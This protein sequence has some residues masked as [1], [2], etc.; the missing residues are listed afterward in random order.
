MNHSNYRTRTGPGHRGEV[1]IQ[2]IVGLIIIAL[3]AGGVYWVKSVLQDTMAEKALRDRLRQESE[4]S[5]E[6]SSPSK[7]NK[8]AHFWNSGDFQSYYIMEKKEEIQRVIVNFIDEQL[9][10]RTLS[11]KRINEIADQMIEDEYWEIVEE[12]EIAQKS[13]TMTVKSYDPYN[14]IPAD[15]EEMRAQLERQLQ[16][17]ENREEV[18][19][20]SCTRCFLVTCKFRDEKVKNTIQY[21]TVK[22][23]PFLKEQMAKGLVEYEGEWIPKEEKLQRERTAKGLVEYQGEWITPEEKFRREQA[24]KGLVEHQGEWIAKEEKIRREQIAKGLVEYDGKWIT[25]E[26]KIRRER[27]AQGLIEY[28]GEWITKEEKF[29]REQTAKGLVEYDGKWITPAEKLKREEAARNM[30]SPWEFRVTFWEARKSWK[31]PDDKRDLEAQGQNRIALVNLECEVIRQFLEGEERE[32][33]KIYIKQ[34]TGGKPLARIAKDNFGK[35]AGDPFLDSTAF[36][37]LWTEGSP[38]AKVAITP[39]RAMLGENGKAFRD[40]NSE[41][42]FLFPEQ[43]NLKVTLAFECGPND[44]NPIL[45]LKPILKE[46]KARAARISLPAD[47]NLPISVEYGD[48]K[49]LISRYIPADLCRGNPQVE[50]IK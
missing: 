30:R 24:A 26:E 27:V 19:E 32:V 44:N 14:V 23:D 9:K 2:T 8:K 46:Q 15:Y 34:P 28:R 33:K 17:M 21:R 43:K 22:E 11:F 42:V 38:Q 31:V 5:N 20:V 48:A 6:M 36:F 37:L 7:M 41:R 35:D 4:I 12:K 40:P 29:R 3:V 50:G 49:E 13:R 1:R 25:P 16:S 45:I 47:K 18:A 39:C 10:E